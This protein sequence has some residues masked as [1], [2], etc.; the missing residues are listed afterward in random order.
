MGNR[1]DKNEQLK[2]LSEKEYRFERD[3]EVCFIKFLWF[4]NEFQIIE[5]EV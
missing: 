2:I 4:L 3:Y 5:K 1:E